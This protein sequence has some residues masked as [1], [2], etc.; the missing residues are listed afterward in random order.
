[1]KGVTVKIKCKI[2]HSRWT[3]VLH[4]QL[5]A[6]QLILSGKCFTAVGLVD[7]GIAA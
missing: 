5:I 3:L 7:T 1:M 2:L 4:L 6:L